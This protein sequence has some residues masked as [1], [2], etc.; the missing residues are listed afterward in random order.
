LAT[1]WRIQDSRLPTVAV[2][3]STATAGGARAVG[4][5]A[6]AA[7]GRRE[8]A[9]AVLRRRA[10]LR[11]GSVEALVGAHWTGPGRD[12]VA[13]ARAALQAGPAR[14]AAASRLTQV[15]TGFP[16]YH[17]AAGVGQARAWLG[18]MQS[19][20]GAAMRA[21]GARLLRRRRFMVGGSQCSGARRGL[22]GPFCA[23]GPLW[24]CARRGRVAGAVHRGVASASQVKCPYRR[25]APLLLL[26]G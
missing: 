12:G 13:S 25:G 26:C 8:P 5:T 9:L 16:A 10:A 11:V 1:T 3:A 19:A 21:G 23:A 18:A 17:G 15:L 24:S 2:A 6:A 7:L 22:L 14:G 4:S 20:A